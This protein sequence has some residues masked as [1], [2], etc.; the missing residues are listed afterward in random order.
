M[1]K[2]SESGTYVKVEFNVWFDKKQDI[3]HLTANDQDI[4]G[5]GVHITAKRGTQSDTNLRALLTMMGCMPGDA[6][7]TGNVDVDAVVAAMG[8]VPLNGVAAPV[9]A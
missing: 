7:D 2:K 8:Y 6:Y 4:P 1:V 5:N 9:K 3:V